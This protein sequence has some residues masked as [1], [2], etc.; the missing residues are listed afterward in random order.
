MSVVVD[1][2]AVVAALADGGAIGDWARSAMVGSSLAAPHVMPAEVA[3][4]LRRQILRGRL[5]ITSA[6]L[7]HT[8]L[9]ELSV[10]LF[11]YAP[12][13]RRIWELRE[14]LSPY[15]AWYVAL[16]ES[17]DAPLI[18]LDIRSSRATGPRCEFVVPPGP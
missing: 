5:S 16:A 2:S 17:L 4:V 6:T 1:A 18:T 8:E 12:T 7:A 15:D 9:D 14:N 13:A 3:S 11:P 10:E